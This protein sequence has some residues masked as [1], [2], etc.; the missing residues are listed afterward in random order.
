MEKMRKAVRPVLHAAATGF[1]FTAKRAV[2]FDRSFMLDPSEYAFH[3]GIHV[4]QLI[5]IL[6]D[7]IN[8]I[9][10]L[11]E[12]HLERSVQVLAHTLT[13]QYRAALLG[14]GQSGK[15]GFGFM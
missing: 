6:P 14:S 12:K 15:R 13:P 3:D 9:L 5:V 2:A 10:H 11:I 1:I 8:A 4:K 7:D